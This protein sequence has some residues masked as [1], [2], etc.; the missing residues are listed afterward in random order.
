LGQ[1][2]LKEN[3]ALEEK[4]GSQGKKETL[5]KKVRQAFRPSYFKKIF[6]EV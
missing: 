6:L 4:K 2:G 1:E 5:E 3:K